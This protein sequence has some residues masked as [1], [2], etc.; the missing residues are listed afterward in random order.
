MSL[1]RRERTIGVVV[2]VAVTAWLGD[3]LGFSPLYERYQDDLKTAQAREQ[4]LAKANQLLRNRGRLEAEYQRRVHSGLV[5][6]ASQAEGN[7]LNALYK[8]ALDANLTYSVKSERDPVKNGL[9]VIRCRLTLTGPMAGVARF[10]WSLENSAIPLR[11]EKVQ[12][13][14][15]DP[16]RDAQSVQ[17][18]VSTVCLATGRA[19]A[20][21]PATQ[22]HQK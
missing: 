21:A 18:Q 2:L 1:S 4:E 17:V 8:L 20:T 15:P 16:T 7:L 14:A 22:E 12:I 5:S 19:H 6:E 13:T 9:Q 3:S 10:C 11:L